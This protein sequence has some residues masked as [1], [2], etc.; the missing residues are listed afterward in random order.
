MSIAMIH[1]DDTQQTKPINVLALGLQPAEMKMLSV[2]IQMSNR[3]PPQ[4][5]SVNI[6]S[7]TAME[8]ADVVLIDPSSPDVQ[9]W[10]REH[11]NE[12]SKMPVVW[13]N[14]TRAPVRGHTTLQRPVRWQTLPAQITSLMDDLETPEIVPQPTLT[15]APASPT[16]Q[17]PSTSAWHTKPVAQPS[18]QQPN[19][20]AL[21]VEQ[22]PQQPSNVS[23]ITARSFTQQ[24]N[25]TPIPTQ[26]PAQHTAKRDEPRRD[27][28]TVLVVDD[29]SSSR[30]YISSL[31]EQW[32]CNIVTA[33]SGEDGLAKY[34]NQRVDLV[35]MDVLMPG[36][37]GY[38]ACK[39]IKN[40][41]AKKAVP[42]VMLTAKT[43]PFDRVRGR[44]AGCDAYLTKPANLAKFS[45][46]LD[47]HLPTLR[48]QR[49]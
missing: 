7:L 8:E 3:R 32:D 10:V 48:R 29:S 25:I 14:T 33:G 20:S 41:S 36:M 19:I 42:V 47:K 46:A 9:M 34:E 43:S 39:K 6:G 17:Q 23:P 26:P 44:I 28:P 37:D 11:Y 30:T 5:C 38:E 35:F 24:P 1:S 31:L 22:P 45:E 13:I 18:T 21:Q 4:L 49:A 12:L 40:S 15:V 16:V 2:V 27:R